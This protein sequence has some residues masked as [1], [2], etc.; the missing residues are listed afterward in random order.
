[1]TLTNPADFASTYD[2]AHQA[3]AETYDALGRVTNDGRRSYGWDA[4]SRLVEHAEAG[5]TTLNTYD[6]FGNRLSRR[7][8]SETKNYV[9]NYAMGMPSVL[10]IRDG[11]GADQWYYLYTPGG[12]LVAGIN[13]A[14]NQRYYYFFDEN[15]NTLSV[16]D[17]S[18]TVVARYLY[19]PYGEPLAASSQVENP[20]TFQGKYGVMH[21]G[22]GLYYM[23]AR[24]YDSATCRFLSRDPL[25]STLPKAASPYQYALNSPT[26]YNDPLGLQSVDS[27]DP[28][29][30][31]D[32]PAS[33]R[34]A[35]RQKG[36]ASTTGE[37]GSVTESPTPPSTGVV[38]LTHEEW[39]TEVRRVKQLLHDRVKKAEW[40]WL[41]PDVPATFDSAYL[42]RQRESFYF[43][44][45][46]MNGGELNY[47]FQGMYWKELGVPKDVM[48]GIIYA[49]KQ[50][51]YGRN[52]SVNDLFAA[53]HGYE[54]NPNFFTELRDEALHYGEIISSLP[55]SMG[56]VVIEGGSAIVDFFSPLIPSFG[57]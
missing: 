19:G 57:E 16:V 33:G 15:G 21:E 48:V 7:R 44:G 38:Y 47:Y 36:V 27:Q 54:D 32:A 8:G 50:I 42:K 39:N 56:E 1:M 9:W 34:N 55:E 25:K 3:Q 41:D 37:S 11:A 17:D 26:R 53:C 24:W 31:G 5:T 20:F 4:A 22:G 51:K 13:A 28:P 6:A 45:L 49:Y 43:R 46:V 18:G 29:Q 14:T 35:A 23:R 10:I 2:G 40:G 12:Q 52:P 30:S